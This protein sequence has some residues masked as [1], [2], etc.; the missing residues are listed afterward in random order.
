[1]LATRGMGISAEGGGLATAGFG[2]SFPEQFFGLKTFYGG[3]IQ[4]LS[5]VAVANSPTGLGGVLKINTPSGVKTIYLVETSDSSA[6]S[7]QIKTLTGI[8]SIRKKT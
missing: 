7:V 8:K 4:D 6:S 3:S 1:M 2:I 5:L